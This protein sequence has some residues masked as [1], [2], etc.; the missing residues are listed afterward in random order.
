VPI[1]TGDV[2]YLRGIEVA[3]NAM[4]AADARAAGATF[5]NTYAPT[6]GHD[7]C[8]PESSRDVEGLL[9]GSLALP[10]HPNARGQQAMAD[11]VL[12]ALKG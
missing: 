9:P 1:T 7:F 2:A 8:Q 6:T 3:A 4:L 12:A 11:A 10:F 5:V